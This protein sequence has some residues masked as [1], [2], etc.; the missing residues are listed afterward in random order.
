MPDGSTIAA[1]LLVLGP[2]LGLLGFY[3][4]TLW[5]VWMVPREEHLALVVARRRGW[6]MLNVGFTVATILTSAGLLLL[7]GASSA[8]DGWKALLAAVAVG[9]LVGGGMWC[10]M[11]AIRSRT[12]PALGAMVAA[13]TPTEPAETLLGAAMNGLFGTYVM[14]TSISLIGLAVGL[15]YGDIVAAPIAW[16]VGIAGVACVV[17]YLRSGDIIPA[18]LYL[19]TLIVGLA[20]LVGS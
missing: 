18:V 5:R 9:Y 1:S 13:G 6:T 3:D 10:A 11:L 16:L 15:A 17:W 19:P 2:A 20:L 7:A 8:D 12:T 14:T 4:V